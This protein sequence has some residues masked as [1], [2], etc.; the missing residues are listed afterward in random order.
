MKF[1]R[2]EKEVPSRMSNLVACWTHPC[3]TDSYVNRW[4]EVMKMVEVQNESY[5]ILGAK[6]DK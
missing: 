1:D 6:I 5:S 4:Q 3:E 2:A